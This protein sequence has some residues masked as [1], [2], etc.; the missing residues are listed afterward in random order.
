MEE[1]PL[2]DYL[3]S[4]VM[5]SK[6]NLNIIQ[7][8]VMDREAIKQIEKNKRKERQDKQAWK[9]FTTLIPIERLVKREFAKQQANFIVAWSSLV[10][11]EAK[12]KFHYNFKVGMQV[13]LL[14]YKGVNLAS[15]MEA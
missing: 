2:V 14:G 15:T 8:K 10:V 13:R 7:Q 9:K 6:K 12:N 1:N 5:I 4:H 3:Q 11:R